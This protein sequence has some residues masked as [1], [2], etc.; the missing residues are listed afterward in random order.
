MNRELLKNYFLGLL[1][2]TDFERVELQILEDDSLE[3]DLMQAE[4][5]LIEEYLDANL[6]N[7]EI[8]AFN[9]NYLVTKERRK[10]I[11]FI[12]L[13]KTYA[14]KH[15]LIEAKPGFFEKIKALFARPQFAVGFASIL[16]LILLGIGF[17]IYNNPQN[18]FESE[19]A[20][21]NK[22]D[23]SNLADFK[24]LKILNLVPESLRSV[25]KINFLPQKELTDQVLL[26][27]ALPA[28]INSE[29]TFSVSILQNGK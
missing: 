28:P 20:E 26:R 29:Q 5:D 10:Q 14:E 21:L 4:H 16:V 23:L 3:T 25:D 12:R 24:T 2:P 18:K 13:L 15:P 8:I 22:K 6:S 19:I 27:L 9:Q 11:E 17:L 7:E 1:N